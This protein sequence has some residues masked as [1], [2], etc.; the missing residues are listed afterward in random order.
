MRG[1]VS[2][3]D[4]FVG[5]RLGGGFVGARLGRALVP[6]RR[7]LGELVLE[8]VHVG[9]VWRK[10]GQL[11]ERGDPDP[12]EE[13]VRGPVEV[14]AGLGVLA[15]PLDEATREQRA[16]HAVDVDSP[17]RGDPS[18]RDRLLVGDD[19]QRLQCCLGQP[20]LLALEDEALH[21]RRVRVSA[22]EPPATGD[23]AQLEPATL[24][25]VFGCEVVQGSGHGLHRVSDHRGQLDVVEGLVGDHQ[26]RLE[27]GPEVG[28]LDVER[29]H[30][31]GRH[32]LGVAGDLTHR[33]SWLAARSEGRR[34]RWL[35]CRSLWVS[36]R[37]RR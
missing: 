10:L 24:L 11:V 29:L 1:L 27:G 14:G 6:G 17:D 31:P 8:V 2:S 35:V 26:D 32:A 36:R 21:H 33:L 18:T 15:G 12:L 9:K 25:G 34:H 5:A 20:R 30:L 23:V 7:H 13:V 22:V 19:R 3:S 4:G 28:D 16:H 37:T